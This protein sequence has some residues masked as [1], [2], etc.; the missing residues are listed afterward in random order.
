MSLF[1]LST[2]LILHEFNSNSI[3]LRVQIMKLL[4]MHFSVAFVLGPDI[5]PRTL[6]SH[7]S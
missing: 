3:W 4:I 6:K 7:Y 2:Y 1:L 5:I